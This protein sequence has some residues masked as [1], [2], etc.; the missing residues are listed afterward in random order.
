[1]FGTNPKALD[2]G[3][4]GILGLQG[5]IAVHSEATRDVYDNRGVPM[6]REEPVYQRVGALYTHHVMERRC[7]KLYTVPVRVRK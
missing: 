7:I 2:D 1:A 6:E 4:C 5:N 3:M